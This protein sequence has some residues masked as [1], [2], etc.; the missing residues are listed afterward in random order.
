MTRSNATLDS[1]TQAQSERLAFVDLRLFFTG[2]VGRADLERRFGIASAAASR[3]LACYR[4]LAPQNLAYDSSAKAYRL[5]D[6]FS[7]IFAFSTARVLAWLGQGF[8]DGLDLQSARAIEADAAGLLS[9]PALQTLGVLA[10]A[11]HGGAALRVSYLSLS[12]GAAKRD[13]VPL[14]FVDNGL[15]WHVRAYDRKNARFSDFVINRIVQMQP[16]PDLGQAHEALRNDP[17]WQRLLDLELVAHPGLA[18]PEAVAADY[19]L[20]DGLLTVP[21][22]AALAGYALARWNVDCS[23]E[24]G[25]APQRHHLWLRNSQ[26]LEGVDSAALAPGHVV[27]QAKGE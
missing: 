16:S 13:I 7:P 18:H 3:D 4:A 9:P 11:V 17:Q 24:H 14:A 2:E 8:G 19:G 5:G 15:R 26:V 21:T 1:L 20:K 10:R 6:A 12:S 27:R 22:R 23:L 25:L